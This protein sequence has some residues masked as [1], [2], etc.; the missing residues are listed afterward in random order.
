M[1]RFLHSQATGTVDLENAG[2]DSL[3]FIFSIV[4][5]LPYLSV[6]S[7]RLQDRFLSG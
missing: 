5:I 1:Y 2:R 3:S 7:R 4:I 6:I